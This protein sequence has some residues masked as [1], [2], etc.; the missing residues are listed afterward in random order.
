MGASG[1]YYGGLNSFLHLVDGN[2]VSN[3]IRPGWVRAERPAPPIEYSSTIASERVQC[4]LRQA[5]T[6]T[7]REQEY[8]KSIDFTALSSLYLKRSPCTD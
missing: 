2:W 5:A 1:G 6:E 4:R 8:H 7:H 3:G